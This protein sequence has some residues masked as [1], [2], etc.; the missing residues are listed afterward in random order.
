MIRDIFFDYTLR[1]VLLGTTILGVVSGML[2]SFAVLRQRSLLGDT[3]SHAAL[4]GIALVFLLTGSKAPLVLLLGAGVAG[5]FGTWLILG[6]TGTTSVRE[7][8][9]QGIVLSVFFGLGLV[10]LSYIQRLPTA[11]KAGLDRFLFGQAATLMT[12]D[13]IVMGAIGGIAV[14]LMI[15]FWKEFKILSFDFDYANSMGYPAR[16]LEYFI[17]LLIVSS[18][19]I[20]LQTVGV[21]L[22]S[23]M[24]VIP[25]ASARQWTNRL[26]SM[27]LLSGIFG[28]VAGI[29]GG[30][31]SSS[32]S[33]LPTGP[34]IVLVLGFISF[35][36]IIAAPKRGLLA[37]ALRRAKN[38]QTYKADRLLQ[39]L[40]ELA[41]QHSDYQ[42]PHSIETLR[43]FYPEPPRSV[44]SGLDALCLR[45]LVQ[46]D[47]KG[48]FFLT[49][50]GKDYA[51]E[52]NG[53]LS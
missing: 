51:I 12:E 25:A 29:I 33:K 48:R 32:V 9:I 49:P 22:M 13:V 27:V 52:Q 42:H 5:W 36:S 16:F 41:Q 45:K 3:M 4:P 8:S 2:G 37:E 34:T 28:G 10:L 43:V 21:I 26:E 39:C 20:G 31:I 15:L 30:L 17:T 44:D 23:A 35:T 24:V 6:V 19:I 40:W 14:F 50:A 1:T 7:D 18:V 46:K 11:A 38:K 47:K 53:E